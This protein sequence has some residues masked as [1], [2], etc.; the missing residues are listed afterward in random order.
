VLL[1]GV[2]L[3]LF[4]LLSL[5]GPGSS[6]GNERLEHT[7][8]GLLVA[9]AVAFVLFRAG[10]PWLALGLPLLWNLSQRFRSDDRGARRD[11]P[12]PT[13]AP[14]PASS[15]PMTRDEALRVLGLEPGASRE[16]ILAEYRRLMK[17]VHP[18]VGG[19]DYL[20]SRLNEAKNTLIGS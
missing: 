13:R 15:A 7:L 4:A 18:D 16:R 20:A 19:T 17:K 9:A 1:G 3:L 14:R 12:R 8:I 5:S 11:P 2:L 6:L 10:L